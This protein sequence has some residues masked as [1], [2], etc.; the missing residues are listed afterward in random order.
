MQVALLVAGMVVTEVALL[1]AGPVVMVMAAVVSGWC[2]CQHDPNYQR[3]SS[4]R[5]DR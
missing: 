1:T 2:V 3:G 5:G 4:Y